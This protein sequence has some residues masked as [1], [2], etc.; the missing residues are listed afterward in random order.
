MALACH[1][2]GYLL[3]RSYPAM[4]VFVEQHE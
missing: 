1:S 3:D 2:K 4:P